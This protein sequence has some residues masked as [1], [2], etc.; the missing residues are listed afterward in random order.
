MVALLFVPLLSFGAPKDQV[1]PKEEEAFQPF[2]KRFAEDLAFR[3]KRIVFPLVVRYGEPRLGAPE[4][5]VWGEG[6]ITALKYPLI[7][8]RA[9]LKKEGL[10]QSITVSTTHYAEVYHQRA[11]ADSYRR[12]Y[13]FRKIETCWF[14]E[15]IRDTSL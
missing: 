2:L 5:E 13:S 6:T 10:E 8:S 11:E 9:Q 4:V 14:L 3:M 12:T 15:T 7:L 1:C